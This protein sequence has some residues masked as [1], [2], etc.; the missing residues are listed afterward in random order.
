M[1]SSLRPSLFYV[2]QQ[3]I[4]DNSLYNFKVVYSLK[5]SLLNA[6]LFLLKQLLVPHAKNPK[7]TTVALKTKFRTNSAVYSLDRGLFSL[8]RAGTTVITAF[9][10]SLVS[11]R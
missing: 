5:I 11:L 1:V 8:L 9:F 10:L 4:P 7:I 3:R 6:V 2:V